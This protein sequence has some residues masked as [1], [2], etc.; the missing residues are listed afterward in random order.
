M[1]KTRACHARNGVSTTPG[2]ANSKTS[3][4]TRH[5]GKLGL[6]Q[7]VRI[8]D[9]VFYFAADV[10]TGFATSAKNEEILWRDFFVFWSDT[11]VGR[12]LAW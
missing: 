4:Q 10:D 11:S 3:V 5:P 7:K 12:G 9:K 8:G 6:V 2:V 1:V